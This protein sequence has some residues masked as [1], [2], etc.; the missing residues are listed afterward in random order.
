MH[1]IVPLG[2]GE[3]IL[4]CGMYRLANA[5]RG[6]AQTSHHHHQA[7]KPIPPP[8]PSKSQGKIVKKQKKKKGTANVFIPLH[9]VYEAPTKREG[10]PKEEKQ[11][12]K[13][14]NKKK[15]RKKNRK[16]IDLSNE[17]WKTVPS[18]VISHANLRLVYFRHRKEKSNFRLACK[19][20]R[21]NQENKRDNQRFTRGSGKMQSGYMAHKRKKAEAQKAHRKERFLTRSRN[22]SF[23]A[24]T[25]LTLPQSESRLLRG[26]GQ[27]KAIQEGGKRSVC[28]GQSTV[29]SNAK[30]TLR[31]LRERIRRYKRV[32]G[33][34]TGWPKPRL[35]PHD[36]SVVYTKTRNQLKRLDRQTRRD[37]RIKAYARAGCQR[38][39]YFVQPD[40]RKP[41]TPKV[42]NTKHG[43]IVVRMK[44]TRSSSKEMNEQKKKAK[45]NRKPKCAREQ[46]TP[47]APPIKTPTAPS[48]I[49]RG[50]E[51]S[52]SQ[53]HPMPG[54]Q[55]LR[56]P[57][58]LSAVAHGKMEEKPSNQPGKRKT[59]KPKKKKKKN[60][61]PW[62]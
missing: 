37:R 16:G 25:Q 14:G 34:P 58:R 35:L 10:Q 22:S 60:P 13:G 2:C 18:Y 53:S 32:T 8:S 1:A 17:E 36:D 48:I 41:R 33:P 26:G 49:Q 27:S 47:R 19:G 56:N 23:V 50:I 52:S 40:S 7:T 51:V 31:T 24:T 9:F 38:F 6:P 42:K 15:N 44:T 5:K 29:A 46:E 30:A 28:G 54:L 43:W 59:P 4:S 62:G 3:T 12:D 61:C 11:R 20:P 45:K 39:D 21:A 55:S 57:F